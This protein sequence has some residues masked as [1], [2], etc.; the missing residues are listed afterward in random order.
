[1]SYKELYTTWLNHKN[2]DSEE[3]KILQSMS[4]EEI[5]DAFYTDIAF[6]TAGM[7]GILGPGSNRINIHTI[8][9]ATL[10]YIKEVIKSDKAKER[11][12]AIGYDNRYMSYEL[13]NDCAK[14][15]SMY[16]INAYI[17][18]SLR[19]TP[20]LSYAVRKLNCYGG[21]M[22]TASHNPKEYN[23]YKLYDEH[24]CQLIPTLIKPIIDNINSIDNC[25]DIYLDDSRVDNKFIHFIKDDVDN[26]YYD[27]VMNICLNKDIDKSNLKIIFTPQHG[28]ANKPVKKVLDMGG[29]NYISVE[30]QCSPDPEFPNTISLNPEEHKSYDLAIEYAKKYDGDIILSCDPDADRMGVVVKHNNEY[31]YLT[32]NQ[33]GA[34]LLEYLFSNMSTRNLIANNAIMFNTIVTSDLGEL[35]AKN[36]NVECEKTLTGFKFIGEK[37]ENYN[38]NATKQF[39]FGYEES[40]G[41]LLNDMVRDKDAV[42]ACLLLSEAA[43]FYKLQ[44][45]TL[46]DVLQEIYEKYGYY[47]DTQ[48]SIVANGKDGLEK[49]NTMLSNLRNN[50]FTSID[51]YK[52]VKVEDYLNKISINDN[53][54]TSLDGFDKADVLKYY[55]EDNSWVA[56]RPSGTEPKCKIY[57]CI[58]GKDKE[59]VDSKYSTISSYINEYLR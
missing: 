23:G 5:K 25:L 43:A 55:L 51:K 20:M 53:G 33:S 27:A 59:E 46:Y 47:L 56:I 32:G 24:G 3:L 48:S 11:G 7:R 35:I 14:L 12:V 41:Y 29:Y 15:F 26:A 49:M 13:A 31:I 36:Y 57:Y 34:I 30:E 16:K 45:K 28:T 39:V 42:Q 37:I 6:G 22:I 58:V 17:Y 4:D 40:Y 9:K 1:M 54:L 19:P 21:I 2:V 52:V 38:L 8:R 44:G 10:G 50:P 18:K